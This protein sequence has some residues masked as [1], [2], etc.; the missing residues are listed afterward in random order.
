[1]ILRD[2]VLL[3]ALSCVVLLGLPPSLSGERTSACQ[4]ALGFEAL[5]DQVPDVVGDCLENEHHNPENGDALQRTSRGLLV[6][7][8]ADNFAAFTDGYRTWVAGPYGLQQRLNAERFEW[9]RDTT[10]TP[11][12]TFDVV[13]LGDS[14]FELWD[15][16]RA[17]AP[18]RVANKGTWGQTSAEILRRFQ[19][20][21]AAN[22]PRHVVVIAGANDLLGNVPPSET[23]VNLRSLLSQ[24]E[25]R[26]IKMLLATVP[27]ARPGSEVSGENVGD[28]NR[29]VRELNDWIRANAWQ[30]GATV[31]DFYALLADERG[32]LDAAY[33]DRDGLH[34]NETGYERL[35]EVLKSYLGT[36]S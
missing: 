30:H 15:V 4:F 5:R 36:S 22:R 31:V 27:P 32:Q 1:M 16:Q 18:L 35:A 23:R 21:A 24:A 12:P 6:W 9:E 13:F 11:T 10:A 34:L 20:D 28:Y 33:S 26:A 2:V 14:Y 29:R 7:R 17:F 8:K 3:T 19:D 25:T